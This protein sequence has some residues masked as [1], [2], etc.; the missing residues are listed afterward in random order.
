MEYFYLV[1]WLNIQHSPVNMGRYVLTRCETIGQ[2]WMDRV[3]PPGPKA[4]GAPANSAGY[5]CLPVP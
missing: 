1:I 4:K 3:A 5:A 2:K